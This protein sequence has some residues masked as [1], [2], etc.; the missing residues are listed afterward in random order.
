[1]LI[2]G[3][4]S[5]SVAYK[6]VMGLRCPLPVASF[7][8]MSLGSAR[9]RVVGLLHPT[10]GLCISAIALSPV[11]RV[12][13]CGQVWT[14]PRGGHPVQE[15]WACPAVVHICLWVCLDRD[16]DRTGAAGG[17][18]VWWRWRPLLRCPPGQGVTALVPDSVQSCF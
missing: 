18:W 4:G 3:P 15:G 6:L 1:M 5:I 2:P 13:M 7:P 10:C 16:R 8:G 17:E 11:G 9:P 14:Q 12:L